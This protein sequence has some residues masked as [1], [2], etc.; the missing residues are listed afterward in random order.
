MSITSNL[1]RKIKQGYI[2]AMAKR[3]IISSDSLELLL[4]TMCNTFGGVMFIA[5]AL[6]VISTFIPKV[7]K[8]IEDEPS[9]DQKITEL[10]AKIER[11]HTQL[12][13]QQLSISL[14]NEL[15]ERFKNSP[16]LKDIEK[17]GA[18]KDENAKLLLLTDKE[19]SAA[20]SWLISINR[21]K[22]KEQKSN[23]ILNQQK[24]DIRK[25]SDDLTLLG[26]EIKKAEKQIADFVPP[27][28][29]DTREIGLAPLAKTAKTPFIVIL[30]SDR[31]YRVNNSSGELLFDGRAFI[32]SSDVKVQPVFEEG[33][34]DPAGVV[35]APV[36]G[37]GVYINPEQK[38]NL[39][40]KRIFAPVDRN[41]K[42][43]FLEVNKNS[44]DSFIRVKKF[45][46][47]AGYSIYWFPADKY[48][49]TF[50]K[51]EYKAR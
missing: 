51:A 31:L 5:I 16:H 22:R 10:Q 35:I 32:S 28:P 13:K 36:P 44:F 50:G 23:K 26:A 49:V 46:H 7:I 19:K 45:L 21:E 47:K 9:P 8:D 14:K 1:C 17:L 15:V 12:E 3:P 39:L 24:V 11:L 37:K 48:M 6:V 33:G 20:A 27:R 2:N 34:K 4:D 25:L 43:I 18:M 42:F 40:L 38:S 41:K 29:Q 30:D